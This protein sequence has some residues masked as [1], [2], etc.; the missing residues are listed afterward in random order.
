[1]DDWNPNHEYFISRGHGSGQYR[2]FLYHDVMWLL[3]GGYIRF[4]MTRDF[5][6]GDCHYFVKDD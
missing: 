1:M 3:R 6:D 2:R 4:W 5:G